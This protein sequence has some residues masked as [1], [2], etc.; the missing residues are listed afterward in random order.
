MWQCSY[1]PF[2][3]SRKWNTQIH[4]KRKHQPV[5]TGR[6]GDVL[7]QPVQVHQTKD[8][9]H[10]GKAQR[11]DQYPMLP[12]NH[13]NS[14]IYDGQA[15]VVYQQPVQQH[16]AGEDQPVHGGKAQAFYHQPDQVHQSW[17]HL[18]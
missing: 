6:A 3:S 4:E 8:Q 18:Q 10:V 5:Y 17:E 15:Q 1:C 12:I 14:N 7:Q 13:L 2:T 16:Q 9:Q 11:Q